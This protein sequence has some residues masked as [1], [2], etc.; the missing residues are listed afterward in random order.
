M[1]LARGVYINNSP[2]HPIIVHMC[3]HKQLWQSYKK[4]KKLNKVGIEKKERNKMGCLCNSDSL[5]ILIL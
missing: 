5:L 3:R 2:A 4:L 1:E